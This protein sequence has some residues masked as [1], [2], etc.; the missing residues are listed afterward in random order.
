MQLLEFFRTALSS[1]Q[2]AAMVPSMSDLVK[3]HQLRPQTALVIHR[4]LVSK[5]SPPV[6]AN[7]ED[8]EI[9]SEAAEALKLAQTPGPNPRFDSF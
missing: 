1:E 2:Y 7:S 5:L 8:G 9:A 6:M 4:P 3:V